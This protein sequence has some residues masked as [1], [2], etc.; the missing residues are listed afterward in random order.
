M[1]KFW[2]LVYLVLRKVWHIVEATADK[3]GPNLDHYVF[4]FISSVTILVVQLHYK[5]EWDKGAIGKN[6]IWDMP[7]QLLTKWGWIV[8]QCFVAAW[9]VPSVGKNVPDM[10]WWFVLAITAFGLTGRWGLEWLAKMK[11]VDIKTTEEDKPEESK[12]KEA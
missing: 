11:G 10:A 12:P 6:G 8:P 4:W 1:D 5:K 2:S 7:E 9:F 3:I